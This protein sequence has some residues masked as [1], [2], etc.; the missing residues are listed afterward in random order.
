M[1]E[2]EKLLEI[3]K[4]LTVNELAGE[5]G[6]TPQ[7][8]QRELM[9]LGILANLNAQVTVENAAK[10]GEKM[11]FVVVTPTPAAAKPG[12]TPAAKAAPTADKGKGKKAR[13][14]GPTPRPPI[15]VVMGHVDH[16]K[17]TLL[18]TIRKTDVAAKEF[19]GITQ[20][21]GAF[22]TAIETGEEREGRKVMRRLTFLD[23]PGHEAFTR[24]RARG[25]GVADIAVLVVAADDGIMPQTVEAIDHAKAAGLPMVVAVNKVDLE[26][27]N[28][29]RVLTELTQHGIVPE[30][31]GG[32]TGTVQISAKQGL[33][34]DDLLDRLQLEAE[35]LELTADANGPAE[36]VI[37]EARLDPGRGPVATVL[38]ESGTL[39]AGDSVVVGSIYG[40]IKAMSDDRANKVNRA[41]PATPVEI[42]GLSAVPSAGDRLISVESDREARQL[43]QE[44]SGAERE[45]KFGA[46]AGRLSLDTL[47][48]QIQQGDVKELNIIIKADVQGSA[49]A[50]RDSLEK[51]STSE[52]RVKVLRVGVGNIGENDVLLASAS[53]A[54]VFGFGVKVDPAARK[55]AEDQGIETRTYRIIYE[56][57][58]AVTAAMKGLLA[59]VYQEVRLGRAEVRATFKLPNNNVVAGCYVTEGVIRR[60]AEIR[61]IRGKQVLHE[62]EINSLR[63][64]RENVREM[65]AGYECG[66]LLDGFNAFEEGDILECFENQQVAREL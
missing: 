42:L 3:S 40:K 14:T 49:E 27:A 60:N 63:H 38:V 9:N 51:L 43:A 32:E 29:D 34:I 15:I 19:G 31:Y 35:L 59:P 48:A 47:F 44:R 45:A 1:P 17:T 25:S 11:G 56:L 30:D 46:H 57:I 66:I 18:D 33:G 54:M 13:P 23:T 22:Q 65:A 58:D 53:N 24:M 52:V 4:P 41:G 39:Y 7:T 55:A 20:H 16:G 12:A 28:P 5:L 61:V 21:I 50:V 62:G 10:V 8:V 6:V 64:V 26:D 36:G 2:E 37:L